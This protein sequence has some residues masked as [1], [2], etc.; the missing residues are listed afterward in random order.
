MA[1]LEMYAGFACVVVIMIASLLI[2]R[3]YRGDVDIMDTVRFVKN[4]TM[5]M[6][7]GSEYG[8][9]E[10]VSGGLDDMDDPLVPREVLVQKMEM[11]PLK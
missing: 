3:E 10:Y 6:V 2:L 11:T 7:K 9:G 5:R 8:K 1:F 4:R